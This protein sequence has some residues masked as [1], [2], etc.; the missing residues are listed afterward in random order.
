MKQILLIE[1]DLVQQHATKQ[2]LTSKGYNVLAARTA[3]SAMNQAELMKPDVIVLELQLQT[4][5]GVEFLHEFRSYTEWNTVPVLLY[6]MV[7]VAVMKPYRK[8]LARLGVVSHLY[9]PAT[10]IEQLSL[11]IE[12]CIRQTA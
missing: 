10:S 5:G 3:E 1:P 11:K 8:Q 7:P 4:H 2:I 6:T 12:H 9:K